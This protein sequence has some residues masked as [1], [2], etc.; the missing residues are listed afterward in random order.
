MPEGTKSGS[1][2]YG[3]LCRIE[4]MSFSIFSFLSHVECF[5]GGASWRN[6]FAFAALK[7]DGTVVAWGD[8]SKGGNLP[9]GLSNVK[10]IYSTAGAYAALKNDGTVFTWGRADWGELEH[11]QGLAMSRPYILLTLAL[12]P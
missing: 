6:E 8:Q 1:Y 5:I 10:T 3:T 11:R 2:L 4:M 9:T 7:E 12:L